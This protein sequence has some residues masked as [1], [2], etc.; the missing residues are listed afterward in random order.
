MGSCCGNS[1]KIIKPNAYK[2]RNNQLELKDQITKQ[3][4]EVNQIYE[5]MQEARHKEKEL[6]LKISNSNGLEREQQIK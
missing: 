4:R 2:K 3:Q 1:V 5:T 6:K